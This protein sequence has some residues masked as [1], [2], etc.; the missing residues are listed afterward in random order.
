MAGVQGQD[1]I[2]CEL[3][4][5]PVENHCNLCHVDLCLSCIPNHMGD[6]SRKH[7]IVEYAS[8]KKE[9]VFLPTCSSHANNHCEAYCE[10]CETP[11]CILRLMGLHK[12]HAFT[13]INESLQ[14]EK[15]H[16]ISDTEELE[17]T[18]LP[19]YR[20]VNQTTTAAD[21]D[22]VLS[23]IEE[24]EEKN[25]NA[26][27]K[28]GIQLKDNVVE[29]KRT[30]LTESKENQSLSDKTEKELDQVIQKNKEV[31]RCNDASTIMNYR[32]RNGEFRKGP[33]LPIIPR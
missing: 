12:N 18:I 2:R 7:E 16:I 29:E 30:A 8:R 31:L 32:S 26:V 11:I 25:C 23:T 33:E 4:P 6:K 19:N 3:C 9:T 17:N 5:N 22:K 15:Q 13:H 20:N 10:D 24:Q 21:F 27:H 28:A 14:K 1:V